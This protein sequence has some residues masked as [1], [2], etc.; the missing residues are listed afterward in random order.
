MIGIDNVLLVSMLHQIGTEEGAGRNDLEPA[1]PCRCEARLD[2]RSAQS[3]PAMTFGN[4]RMIEAD[5]AR[6]QVV[7]G[8]CDLAIA[9]V[10]LEPLLVDIV[11]DNGRMF[12]H[13]ALLAA[14]AVTCQC[15]IARQMPSTF[16]HKGWPFDIIS[17]EGS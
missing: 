9:E 6:Q 7:G 2:Q 10:N 13:R 1:F 5:F 8:E 4:H 16:Q 3:L 15:K 11:A 14:T 17:T 12:F